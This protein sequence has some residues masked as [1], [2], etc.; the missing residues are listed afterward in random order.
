MDEEIHAIDYFINKNINDRRPFHL[1]LL[2]TH[3]LELFYGMIDRFCRGND[4]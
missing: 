1:G 3:F 2:S 4:I